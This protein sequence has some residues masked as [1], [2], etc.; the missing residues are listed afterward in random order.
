MSAITVRFVRPA[1][2]RLSIEID[3]TSLHAYLDMLGVSHDGT[4][5]ADQPSGGDSIDT[6]SHAIRPSLLLRV[7]VQTVALSQYYSSPVS[8]AVMISLAR[9]VEAAALAV[10]EHYRPVSLRVEIGLKTPASAP[11]AEAAVSGGAL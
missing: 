3:A 1:G 11:V 6:Y 9:S 2:G 4:R 8:K 7:G 10:I 5:Y